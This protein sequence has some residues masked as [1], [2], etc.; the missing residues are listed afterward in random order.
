MQQQQQSRHNSRATR[1]LA[2]GMPDETV[3]QTPAAMATLGWLGLLAGIGAN[4]WQMYTT[5]SAVYQMFTGSTMPVID[6]GNI[7]FDICFLIAL[8]F[9]LA[10]LFLVFRLDTRWKKQQTGGSA[11]RKKGGMKSY[12]YAAVEV[13][14]QLGLFAIWVG[15]AFVID[16]LGD[17]TFIAVRTATADASTSA[18]LVF[19]YAVALY[20]LSTLVLV[21]AIEYLWSASAVKDQWA[22][23]RERR[24]G[25][26]PRESQPRW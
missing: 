9:Q 6:F 5:I 11:G 3:H 17:F 24:R 25:E 12:G 4:L 26:R 23:S 10:L 19:L 20:S 8:S 15:L 18:F 14:Q 1:V 2:R 22:Q 21:R 16:T 7:T 13:V